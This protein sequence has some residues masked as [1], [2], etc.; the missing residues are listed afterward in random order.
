MSLH[1]FTVVWT[2]VG[3]LLGV[4]IGG[5]LTARS[6]SRKWV[7]DGKKE[8]YREVLSAIM[9]ALPEDPEQESTPFSIESLKTF[10]VLAT[11]SLAVVADRILI[12]DKMKRL[13]VGKKWHQAVTAFSKDPT[14]NN[15][16]NLFKV[17][18]ELREEIV[19]S[20]NK[21]KP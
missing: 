20:A 14:Q 15:S 7:A 9:N 19:A 3:P 1:D 4:L 10:D 2:A 17:A 11:R 12:S 21:V 8:E 16:A 13:D 5:Y 6:Q 18:G